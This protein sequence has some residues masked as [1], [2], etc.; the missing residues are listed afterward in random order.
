MLW[1]YG[2]II[3][4]QN[5]PVHI[6]KMVRFVQILGNMDHM[7]IKTFTPT[8]EKWTG[9]SFTK[10]SIL[11]K[12]WVIWTT[13]V[14]WTGSFF[15]KLRRSIFQKFCR[16]RNSVCNIYGPPPFLLNYNDLLPFEHAGMLRTEHNSHPESMD[17]WEAKMTTL[18]QFEV[19]WSIFGQSPLYN[20]SGFL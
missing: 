13:C 16:W 20:T 1:Q 10:W 17:S 11:H 18:W 15:K 2:P 6:P 3:I 14:I 4:F 5:G 7:F 19:R 12:M 9:P 8:F